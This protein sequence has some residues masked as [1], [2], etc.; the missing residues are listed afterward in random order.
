M[1]SQ[2]RLTFAFGITSLLV[3]SQMVA[4]RPAEACWVMDICQIIWCSETAPAPR[5]IYTEVVALPGN[6]ALISVSGGVSAPMEAE[7]SCVTGIPWVQDIE[8]PVSVRMVRPDSGDLVYA[9]SPSEIPAQEFKNL[10]ERQFNDMPVARHWLGFHAY[11]KNASIS[12]GPTVMQYIVKLRPGA[13]VYDLAKSLHRSGVFATGSAKP[14]GTLDFHH[15]D[16]IPFGGSPIV[17]VVNP[18]TGTRER[19]SSQN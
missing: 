3:A 7:V 5:E 9:F 2:N 12:T 17:T 1:R 10:A 6:R 4:P 11:L 8:K 14:D 18:V 19:P 13:T 15:W 16:L